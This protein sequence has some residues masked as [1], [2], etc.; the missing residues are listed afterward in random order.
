M[1]RSSSSPAVALVLPE[2]APPAEFLA[3]VPDPAP[4]PAPS[5][6]TLVAVPD[7]PPSPAPPTDAAGAD[8]GREARPPTWGFLTAHGQVLLCLL[9][10]PNLRIHQIAAQVGIS[11]RT[12]HRVLNQLERGGYVRRARDGQRNTYEIDPSRRLR[13]PL[14]SHRELGDLLAVLGGA[15]Q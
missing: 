6:E 14:V 13:H 15:G 4:D 10:Y 7:P 11:P 1:S 12:T 8:A 3:A 5:A 2:A 9:A